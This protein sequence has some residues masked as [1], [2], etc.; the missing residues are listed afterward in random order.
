MSSI[1]HTAWRNLVVSIFFIRFLI[2]F[3]MK[4]GVTLYHFPFYKRIEYLNMEHWHQVGSR[5]IFYLNEIITFFIWYEVTASLRSDYRSHDAAILTLDLSPACV[6]MVQRGQQSEKGHVTGHVCNYL[7]RTWYRTCSEMLGSRET[8]QPGAVTPTYLLTHS[9]TSHCVSTQLIITSQQISNLRPRPV[10]TEWYR[11]QLRL[12]IAAA[13]A[14]GSWQLAAP[15]H[16][17]Q[18]LQPPPASAPPTLR[19]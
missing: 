12:T 15:H 13:E 7:K 17:Q 19:S 10:P 11:G 18:Q 2:L 3:A 16:A 1:Y 5:G 9:H 14:G 4:H 6:T 8:R